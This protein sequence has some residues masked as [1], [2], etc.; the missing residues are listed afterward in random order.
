MWFRLILV[1]PHVG[2]VLLHTKIRD[3][4]S[5][6]KVERH[7]RTLKERW[8][9]T[10]DISSIPSLAEFNRLLKDYMRSYVTFHQTDDPY[11]SSHIL[12]MHIFS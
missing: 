12:T 7:F 5:K 9:Y 6:G 11:G 4:A 10:L 2:T 1:C 3:G 8:L